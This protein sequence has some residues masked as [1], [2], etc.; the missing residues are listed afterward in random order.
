M[1]K[2]KLCG[3]TIVDANGGGDLLI[4]IGNSETFWQDSHTCAGLFGEAYFNNEV[5]GKMIQEDY[6]LAM[7]QCVGL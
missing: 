6:D 2:V 4:T 5:I 7:E 1:D 3:Y